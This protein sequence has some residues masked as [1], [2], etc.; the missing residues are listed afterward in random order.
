MLT[1]DLDTLSINTI[2][3]LAMDAVQQANSGH[4]GTPMAMAPVAYALWQRHLRF[5][6]ERSD[7]AEPRPLRALD[8][9]RLDAALLDAAPG[10]REGREP[11]VRDAR[12]AVGRPRRHQATSASSTAGA[13]AIP[14][15]AGRPA[16]RRR[17]GR[18]A[19]GS[20]PASGWRSPASGWP[21]T[22]T[23]RTSRC[24]TSTSTRWRR[25]LPD[26]GHL[27]ARRR[28][29]P[30][31]CS[32]T[33]CA[34]S[35]TTTTSRSRGTR[36]S[37]SARTWRRGSSRYGWNVTRV[38]DANDL[39][40]L[41]RAFATFKKT[42]GRPTLI[43][44]D[45]HIGYG[46]PTKQDTH[47]AHGEPLGEEEIR[48]AKRFYGW[49]EDAKFL[50][51]DGVRE[52]FAAG[53]GARGAK[54]R[55]E[56][57]AR[58]DALQGEVSRA[59]PTR[60]SACSTGSCP[61]AGSRRSR[62][63]PPTPKGLAGRDASAKVL[64]AVAQ[65]I[66]WLIGG[67]ADLAPSTKTRLTFD[68]AGDFEAG[69]YARPQLP[70]RRPRARDGRGAQRP[71]AVEDPAVRLRLPDLQRLRPRADP[72]RGDHGD[73]GHLRLHARLDRRRRGRADASAG[74]A[75]PVA[76]GRSRA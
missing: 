52:H 18:S 37:P 31:T 25:R 30:A 21:R 33:T 46:A 74:R 22:S 65:R 1:T 44:V 54:L 53:I 34:G 62:A 40:M 4:P 66:P 27:V 70:F 41:D 59:K 8:G 26:G 49:P 76:C 61:T 16:S 69:S 10:R 68:G 7:L 60:C 72:A 35:T 55:E 38:G 51:P 39:E 56:W 73:P 13:R 63:F 47:A 36:R 29:S 64:N 45:S 71:V 6:P 58:F 20:R 17:P 24:S 42:T 57:L 43:I 32:S 2:R 14:N 3:T 19:R 48:A 50:V 23:A 15:T 9:A 12:A 75:A 67:S 28:R 5:D 11:E